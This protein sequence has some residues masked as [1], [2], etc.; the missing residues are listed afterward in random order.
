[1]IALIWSSPNP[2]ISADVS[3]YH[4]A[5]TGLGPLLESFERPDR[6]LSLVPGAAFWPLVRNLEAASLCIAYAQYI[7]QHHKDAYY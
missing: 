3:L 5:V 6:R 7:Y 4:I 2:G 1:L